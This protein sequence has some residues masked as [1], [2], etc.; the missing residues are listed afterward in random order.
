VPSASRSASLMRRW[1]FRIWCMPILMLLWS[2]YFAHYRYC[3]LSDFTILISDI[4]LVSFHFDAC[5]SPARVIYWTNIAHYS[6]PAMR[7]HR[8]YFTYRFIIFHY[9]IGDC[10]GFRWFLL[11]II[12]ASWELG[13]SIERRTA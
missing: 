9:L 11:S 7:T 6:I 2:H 1:L 5:R 8:T 12:T 13:L 10:T 3:F 4:V